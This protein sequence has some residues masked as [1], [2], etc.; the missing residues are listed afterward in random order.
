VVGSQRIREKARANVGL[1]YTALAIDMYGS[2]KKAAHPKEAGQFAAEAKNDMNAAAARFRS[3][4]GVLVREKTVDPSKLA[5]IGYC[6]G[7]GIVLEMVRR[8]ATR[9]ERRGL[10][11][12]GVVSFHGSLATNRPATSG[13]GAP[14][15]LVLHGAD[16]TFIAAEQIDLFKSEMERA[17]IDYEF[18]AYEGAKHSFTNPDADRLAEEFGLGIAY[19]AEAD[20]QSWQ[21]MQ[22]FF[23][24]IFE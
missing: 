7:G 18:V 13:K 21:K 12:S 16:D 17:G 3:A 5:A 8:Q 2:G 11:L 10:A 4:I 20:K 1:G 9:I 14:K 19:D 6:F 23:N 15:V 22:E 24:E